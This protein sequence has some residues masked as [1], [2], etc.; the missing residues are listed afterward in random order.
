M[1]R[2]PRDSQR[3]AVYRWE[4]SMTA[5]LLSPDA[6]VRM[7][8]DEC[9]AL[10]KKVSEDYGIR[11]PRVKDGR[12]TTMAYAY[13]G[14]AIGLPLFSRKALTVIHEMAHIILYQTV[15]NKYASHGREF[16]SLVLDMYKRYLG[17]DHVEAR[18]IGI[19]QRPRRVRF[20]NMKIIPKP[21]K[22]VYRYKFAELAAARRK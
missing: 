5:Q 19:V 9:K 21:V 1:A 6:R 7:T 13:G 16:A 8:L 11:E 20:A 4:W 3:N 22:K 17:L 12:G 15:Q 2:R 18:K 14:H 10:V